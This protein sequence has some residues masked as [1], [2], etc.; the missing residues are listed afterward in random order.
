M[1]IQQA[2][3]GHLCHL[4]LMMSLDCPLAIRHKKGEYILCMEI[5]GIFF[6]FLFCFGAYRLHLGASLMYFFL[7][8]SRCIYF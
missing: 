3:D 7:F 8:G 4:L 2:L 1:Q 5:G 6:F